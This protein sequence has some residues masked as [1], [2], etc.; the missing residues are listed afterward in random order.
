MSEVRLYLDGELVDIDPETE[1]VETK[2]INN[3]FELRDRQSSFTNVLTFLLTN[4]TS[5][6]L[7]RVGNSY[8]TSIKP[9]R[10]L[11]AEVYRGGTPTITDGK[12]IIKS[13][14]G[15]KKVTGNII[16]GLVSLFDEI[17]SKSLS[18][19][20]FSG[21]NHTFLKDTII[22][23]FSHEWQ[24]GYIYSIADYGLF[25]PDLV[26][27]NYQS[28]CLYIKWIFEQIFIDS[29][30][31]YTYRGSENPLD[32]DEF[33][34]KAITMNKGI[35]LQKSSATPHVP[36]KRLELSAI[37]TINELGRK[38]IRM[39]EVFDPYHYHQIT[40]SS[41][42][43]QSLILPT[44]NNYYKIVIEGDLVG[45]A[46]IVIEL[47]DNKLN[48]ITPQIGFSKEIPIYLSVNSK[49]KIYSEG[50]YGYSYSFTVKMYTD[51]GSNYINFNSFLTNIKQADFLKSILQMYGLM[52][53]RK[54]GTTNYE[55][56]RVEDLFQNRLDAQDFSN[57]FHK[58]SLNSE[59]V[60]FRI[61]DYSQINELRYL[62]DDDGATFSNGT[63][64]IDDQTLTKKR[65]LLTL[66]YKS[67]KFSGE[68]FNDEYVYETTVFDVRRNED[69][70][71]KEV[72][73]K[74]TNPYIINIL[75]KTGSIS[76]FD[77]A[78][79]QTN[80]FT[81]L[82][83]SNFT[84]LNLNILLSENYSSFVRT[85]NKGKLY[86]VELELTAK[87]VY[88]FDFFKLIYLE[89]AQRYFYCNKIITF[90]ENK[91]TRVEL[92]EVDTSRQVTGEYSDD[93]SRDYNI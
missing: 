54:K 40:S 52:F 69:G 71:I 57:K 80:L 90:K 14:I 46:K 55:L 23:S 22:N 37:E 84:D 85:I 56:I 1:I 92:I 31:S 72:K 21:L 48:T 29:G 43:N 67:P 61:G 82:P 76:Y 51:N 83:I 60:T 36:E 8:N 39:V 27:L 15:K 78:G 49:L 59:T 34:S 20:N 17:G 70:S 18:S 81:T 75:K 91:V 16:D 33:K 35:I 24:D 3:L 45:N 42:N 58:S 86:V 12:F 79:V 38:Y 89:Q 74:D 2:Q 10:F 50:D 62:Y 7:N 63:F 28:P 73:P 64:F 87:D 4:E 5:K 77:E 9:F 26:D 65:T 11:N 6:E 66:P 93:Y 30:F 19:L 44:E 41:S 32:S 47:D 53:Q 25:N 13:I 88:D 68:T